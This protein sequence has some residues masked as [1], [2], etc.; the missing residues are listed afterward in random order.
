MSPF[1]YVILYQWEAFVS[2]RG[3]VA[4]LAKHRLIRSPLRLYLL[5]E[6]VLSK[7]SLFDEELTQSVCLGQGYQQFLQC[8]CFTFVW[9]SDW[10]VLFLVPTSQTAQPMYSQ[11]IMKAASRS[12]PNSIFRSQIRSTALWRS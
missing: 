3:L 7:Y 9:F 11:A 10:C 5:H 12:T 1:E 6:P 2:T 4:L 8:D